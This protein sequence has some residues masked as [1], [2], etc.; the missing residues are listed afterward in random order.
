MWIP[1]VILYLCRTRC[2]PSELVSP[3]VLQKGFPYD[4]LGV[5]LTVSGQWKRLEHEVKWQKLEDCHQFIPEGPA[6]M[7]VTVF[8]TRTRRE[9]CLDD[10]PASV[11]RRK[12]VGSQAHAVEAVVQGKSHKTKSQTKLRRMMEKEMPFEMIAECDR[13][14]YKAA[15]EKE[16]KSWLDYQSC[17]ILSVEQSKRVER[18]RPERILSSRY[19]FRNKNVGLKDSSGRDLPVKAKARLC[20]QGHLCPDSRTG[21]LEVDSPT[22]ERVSIMIFLHLVTN[23]GWTKNL[24]HR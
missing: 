11:K 4:L 23:F 13:E 7:L 18:E 20:L 12:G 3:G 24:V 17:E 16:W 2:G 9:S 22:I 19:V 15:E 5:I 1:R 10:V 21:K 14:L 8:Q 6:S